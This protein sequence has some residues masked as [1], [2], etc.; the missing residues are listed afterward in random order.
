MR[1]PFLLQGQFNFNNTQLQKVT[2]KATIHSVS[3]FG[4][5]ETHPYLLT[6][7]YMYVMVAVNIKSQAKFPLLTSLPH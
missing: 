4:K 7:L 3:K 1:A 2:G 5:Y 6:H